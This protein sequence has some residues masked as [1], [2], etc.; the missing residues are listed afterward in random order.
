MDA[1]HEAGLSEEAFSAELNRLQAERNSAPE[2]SN[3]A[4]MA[5]LTP[6][7]KARILKEGLPLS[8]LLGLVPLAQVGRHGQPPPE[9]RR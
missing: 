8:V 1:L 9:P 4:W 2:G 6:E 7:M 3:E 5:R